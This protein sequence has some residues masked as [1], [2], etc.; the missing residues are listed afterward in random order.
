MASTLE[1]IQDLKPLASLSPINMETG[2][3]RN[4]IPR[5]PSHVQTTTLQG[6][7]LAH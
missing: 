6:Q 7:L 5:P 1:F 2:A 3:Q 4:Q